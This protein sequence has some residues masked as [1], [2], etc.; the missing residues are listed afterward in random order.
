MHRCLANIALTLGALGFFYWLVGLYDAA[1]RDPR[2]LDGWILA[3]GMAVQL[4]FHVRKKFPAL[5]WGRAT[6]WMKAHTYVGYFIGSP[7]M[8]VVPCEIEG[9]TAVVAGHEIALA[10]SYSNL[11]EGARIELGARPEFISLSADATGHPVKVRRVDDVGR[12]KI[13]NVALA[14]VAFNVVAPEEARI[15]GDEAHIVFDTARINVYA[16]GHLVE[17]DPR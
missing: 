13:A 12:Y 6:T 10:H 11:P 3:A 1:L 2:L 5:T 14:D 17:G 7:G 9:A 15:V 16:D 4:L 8:N